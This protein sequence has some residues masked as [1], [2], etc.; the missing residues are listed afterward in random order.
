M[1]QNKPVVCHSFSRLLAVSS[2]FCGVQVSLSSIAVADDENAF[3][4]SA[5]TALVSDYRFRGISLSNKDI[6]IQGGFDLEHKSGFYVGAWASSIEEFA[7]AETE[8][9]IYGGY[10]GSFGDVSTDIGV[11]A[12]TFPGGNGVDYVELYGSLGRSFGSVDMTIGAAYVW[13]QDNVGGTDNIYVYLNGETPLGES[14][15]SASGHI[16]YEDGAFGTNKWDW[17]LGLSYAISD[18]FS[19]GVSYIDT[20]NVGTNEA[21]AGVVASLSASF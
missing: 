9:D 12:Y 7:G 21:D 13:D 5:N 20:A 3:L 4:L 10:A 6:A 1:A 16:A 14:G 2:V 8:L 15:L 11:L 19:L 17:S 18:R